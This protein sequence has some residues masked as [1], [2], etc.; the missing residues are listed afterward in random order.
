[1]QWALLIEA[2]EVNLTG[3]IANSGFDESQTGPGQ[4]VPA[5]VSRVA[6][7]SKKRQ[8]RWRRPLRGIAGIAITLGA[9]ELCA[10]LGVVNPAF[11]SKPSEVAVAIWQYF[12]SGGGLSALGISAEEFAIGFA[13]ALVIGLVLGAVIGWWQWF[14]DF[15]DPLVVFLYATP[16][17]A[18][19][20]LF[21]IW[22]GIGIESRVAVILLSAVFPIMMSTTTGVKT[23]DA[24]L[25]RVAR[26]F[27]ATGFQTFRTVVLPGATPSVVTGIRLGIGHGIVGMV[28]A[29][30]VASTGGLGYT[31]EIAGNN[32][33]TPLMFAA[34]VI[35]AV[36]GL[37]ITQAFRVLERR[38]DRWRPGLTS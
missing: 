12:Q 8:T 14:E 27:N 20:P 17:I 36:I 11:S 19:V 10:D 7:R 2:G 25:V 15:V 33:R 29:E 30:L 6:A 37:I 4:T 26:A 35:V 13:L 3:A 9:W 5:P 32:F 31:I 21:I 28:V 24:A 23:A 16:R 1:M 18:L 34:V 22:F 38:L